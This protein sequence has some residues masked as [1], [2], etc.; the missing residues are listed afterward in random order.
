[1][2]IPRGRLLPS[3]RKVPP[4]ADFPGEFALR[5]SDQGESEAER[6]GGGNPR[7]P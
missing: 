7:E 1:M 2:V 5:R 6:K 4:S 3:G